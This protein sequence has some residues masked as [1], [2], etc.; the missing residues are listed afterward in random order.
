MTQKTKKNKGKVFSDVLLPM[1]LAFAIVFVVRYFIIG[2]YYIPSESM[3]PTFEVNDHVVVT[4]F[5]YQLHEPERGDIIVFKYPPNDMSGVPEE[6]KVDYVKRVIGLPGETLE[7]KDGTV[8]INGIPLKEP[9]L[10]EGT[11]MGDYGPYTLSEGNY[12]AMGDN[13]NNS[14]DSRYWG[15][16]GEEYIEGKAQITYWPIDRWGVIR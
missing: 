15:P 6:E 2:M 9:Y 3:V 14:N 7:I 16:V 8:H 11:N 10:N 13:R 1:V 4:K 12:F 5:T